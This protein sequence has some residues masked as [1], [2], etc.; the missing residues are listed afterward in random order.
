MPFRKINKDGLLAYYPRIASPD[1][2]LA[3][4]HSI[5]ARA[6]LEG[7]VTEQDIYA[8]CK[9]VLG[10]L[11]SKRWCLRLLVEYQEWSRN[12]REYDKL[13]EW[14]LYVKRPIID[15]QKKLGVLL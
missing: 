13:S 6:V 1:T 9:E 2:K 12:V 8:V 5:R 15:N 10:L 7:G 11:P 14:S 4:Y 3:I